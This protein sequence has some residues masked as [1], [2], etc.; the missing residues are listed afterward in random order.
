MLDEKKKEQLYILPSTDP[1]TLGENLIGIGIQLRML[2][3]GSKVTGIKP[4]KETR[5]LI[6]EFERG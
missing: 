2:Q 4:D 5:R 1:A 6:I 3:K